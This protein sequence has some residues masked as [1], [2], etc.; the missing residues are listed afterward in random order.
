MIIHDEKKRRLR[1]YRNYIKK[2]TAAF[3]LTNSVPR[4]EIMGHHVGLLSSCQIKVNPFCP[5]QGAS[6]NNNDNDDNNNNNND[7]DDKK[8][9]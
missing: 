7:N 9:K 2:K 5:L 1:V 6:F 4:Q 8:S 3:L